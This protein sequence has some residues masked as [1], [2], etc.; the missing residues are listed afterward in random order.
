MPNISRILIE[1]IKI[2]ISIYTILSFLS[3]ST[4]EPT[5]LIGSNYL[6]R[7]VQW[8]VYLVGVE[9]SVI[10][11]SNC[12][13][14][15]QWWRIKPVYM[16]SAWFPVNCQFQCQTYSLLIH[17]LC[18]V[19]NQHGIKL[20]IVISNSLY[21]CQMCSITPVFIFSQID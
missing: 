21:K 14:V 11:T 13:M 19:L 8:L 5:N 2:I 10:Y 20:I 3:I 12:C 16:L 17:Q 9:P 1:I 15:L 6:D 4:N 7:M 18:L